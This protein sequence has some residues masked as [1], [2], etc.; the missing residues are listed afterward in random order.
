[1]WTEGVHVIASK[2][3]YI[4]GSIAVPVVA[5]VVDVAPLL[6]QDGDTGR[7]ECIELGLTVVAPVQV[8]ANALLE[9]CIACSMLATVYPDASKG[10]SRLRGAR[11]LH[12]RVGH[13][14]A[15]LLPH[16]LLT[17]CLEV[18]E[19]ASGETQLA[20]YAAAV[21]EKRKKC[22]GAGHAFAGIRQIALCSPCTAALHYGGHPLLE[23]IATSIEAPRGLLQSPDAGLALQLVLPH[24]ID[25][26]SISMHWNKLLV[27]T[28]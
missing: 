28:S 18:R 11:R 6:G 23:L 4:R 3:T 21:G 22:V 10:D 12:G 25:P 2:P 14:D 9:V 26:A 24:R 19:L 8:H 27:C 17:A 16:E 13:V 15:A 7:T 5:G 20:Q 1:V